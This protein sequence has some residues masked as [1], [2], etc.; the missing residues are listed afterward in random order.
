MQ[1]LKKGA[2]SLVPDPSTYFKPKYNF[3]H[4]FSK[5]SLEMGIFKLNDLPENDF[6]SLSNYIYNI[7]M[8]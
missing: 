6:R 1:I 4:T 7:I 3:V 8:Y 5:I 2:L